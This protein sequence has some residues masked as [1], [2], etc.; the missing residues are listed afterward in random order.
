MHGPHLVEEEVTCCGGRACQAK[1]RVP[2]CPALTQLPD[3]ACRRMF[4]PRRKFVGRRRPPSGCAMPPLTRPRPRR[5]ASSS[6]DRKRDVEVRGGLMLRYAAIHHPHLHEATLAGGGR[7]R[8]RWR[9][10]LMHGA[11][12][13]SEK[14]LLTFVSRTP[15]DPYNDN[16]WAY[17]L[18]QA[19]IGVIGLV[20]LWVVGLQSPSCLHSV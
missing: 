7:C 11:G 14:T 10:D 19:Y 6:R 12:T 1:G 16:I 9:R 5:Q 20:I 17:L 3:L 4:S 8:K 18:L 2:P 15:S 13:K